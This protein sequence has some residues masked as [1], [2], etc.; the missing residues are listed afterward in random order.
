MTRS[1]IRPLLA[2]FLMLG[3]LGAGSAGAQAAPR[4]TVVVGA[5]PGSERAAARLVQR[6]GGDVGSRICDRPRLRRPGARRGAAAAAPVGRG[7]QRRP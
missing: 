3:V 6:L 5:Q 2:L 4:V 1:I 7:P